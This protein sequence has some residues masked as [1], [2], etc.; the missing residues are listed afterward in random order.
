MAEMS[1]TLGLALHPDTPLL[2][3]RSRLGVGVIDSSPSWADGLGGE[4]VWR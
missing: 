4:G 3:A 1:L 2:L